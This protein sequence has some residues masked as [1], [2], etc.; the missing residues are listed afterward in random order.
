M[1]S[2]QTTNSQRDIDNWLLNSPM[3]MLAPDTIDAQCWLNSLQ[4][5]STPCT[6]QPHPLPDTRR[7]G[8]WYEH[9]VASLLA[10]SPMLSAIHRNIQVQHER[11]TLG[12][13]DFLCIDQQGA[14]HHLE[15]AI[16]FYLCD[17]PSDQLESYIGPNRK[18]RLA[19]KWQ[20]MTDKQIQLSQSTA[21]LA[22]CR[23]LGLN[24][25]CTQHLL[26]QGYLFYPF[27][28]FIA[29]GPTQLHPAINPQ[30]NRGWWLRAHRLTELTGTELILKRRDKPDWLLNARY[31]IECIEDQQILLTEDSALH[32]PQLVSRMKQQENGVW[33]E[34]DRG[35]VVP[36]NWGAPSENSR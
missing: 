23:Q 21:G 30:H 15:C 34:V 1:P 36:D 25:P 13:F 29:G 33:Q 16:K 7:L 11:R 3:L 6:N 17:G 9:H 31:D 4:T 24:L 22:T 5:S 28:L 26:I 18:D 35:F 27:D 12:E 19:R 2:H 20:Q 14:S 10:Q 8:T 32:S